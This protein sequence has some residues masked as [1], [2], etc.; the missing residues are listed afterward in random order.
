MSDNYSINNNSMS[1]FISYFR[2]LKLSDTWPPNK[3]VN[4]KLFYEGLCMTKCKNCTTP[5]N[6]AQHHVSHMEN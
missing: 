2:F 6:L 5:F 4:L 1:L 3:Y